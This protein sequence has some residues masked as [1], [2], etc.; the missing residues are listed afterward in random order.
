MRE[1]KYPEYDQHKKAH[2]I[3]VSQVSDIKKKFD[4]G[5]E[6]L[7]I[8]VFD[9][10]KSWLTNHIQKIDRQYTPYLKGKDVA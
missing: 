3:L 5:E 10:L 7:S 9:F 2:D 8:E 6:V 1:E 4:Q